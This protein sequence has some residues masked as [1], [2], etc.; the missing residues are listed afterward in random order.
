M[1]AK[2]CPCGG[3]GCAPQHKMVR[4]PG[5]FLAIA[6][7]IFCMGGCHREG[8]GMSKEQATERWNA[9]MEPV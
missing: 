6:H 8:V 5:T 3:W 2:R 1:D 4:V 7:V 9:S